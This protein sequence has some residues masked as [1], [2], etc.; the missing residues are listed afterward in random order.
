MNKEFW[1]RRGITVEKMEKV[2][3]E[4]AV[5]TWLKWIRHTDIG[6]YNRFN[7]KQ[8]SLTECFRVK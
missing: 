8:I 3:Q 6:N 7:D 4:N 1:L 5:I 2:R